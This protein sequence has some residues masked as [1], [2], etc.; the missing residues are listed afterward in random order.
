LIASLKV[1]IIGEKT[2]RERGERER[3]V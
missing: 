3:K 1:L 2:R